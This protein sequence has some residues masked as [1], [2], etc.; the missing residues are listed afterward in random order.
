MEFTI[1]NFEQ[2]KDDLESE[3]Q[4]C[5]DQRRVLERAIERLAEIGLITNTPHCKRL[6]IDGVREL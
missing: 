5:R 1:E 4:R 2:L 6:Y 3:Q